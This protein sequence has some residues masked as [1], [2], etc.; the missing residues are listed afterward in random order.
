M[1]HRRSDRREWFQVAAVSTCSL[2]L[3]LAVLGAAT[4]A[5]AAAD[6]DEGSTKPVPPNVYLD[7]RT[8][9]ASIPAGTLGL[10][11]GT[12]SLSAAF[13]ALAA[14]RGDSL[15]GGLPAA[16]GVVMDF[17][18]TVD[19]TDSVSVWGGVSASTTDFGSAGWSSFTVTSWNIGIQADLYSQNG[20][21]FPTVTLQSTLTQSVPLQTGATTTFNN[22]LEFNYAFDQDET[23]GLLAGMQDTRTAIAAEFASIGSNLIVYVG[24]YYQWPSNWKFTGRAGIEKFAGAQLG[25]TIAVQSITGPIVRLDIDRMDDNDNRLFGVT[26]QIAW[27]PKPAYQ[28]TLRTPLFFVRN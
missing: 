10:G 9:Y 4:D 3:V 13:V 28:V 15:P 22:V 16:Q 26:A 11:F 20:G 21:M 14:L 18:L 25:N 8:T 1:A 12:S 6:A 7:V 19:V 5:A 24:G 23:R 2:M 27:T 17:P